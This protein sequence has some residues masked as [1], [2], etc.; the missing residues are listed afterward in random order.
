MAKLRIRWF[1][2]A[3]FLISSSSGVR[4]LTD[5]FDETVGYNLPHTAADIVTSSHDHFDHSNVSVAEGNPQILKGPGEYR[6]DK[7]SVYS[8]ETWHDTEH[9]ARRGKNHVFII[10]ADGVRIVH[11]GDIGHDLIPSQ[12]DA[13]GRVDVLLVPCGGYYTIDAE[14]AKRLVSSTNPRVVIPMHYRT[15]AIHDWPIARVDEFLKR[16]DNVVELDCSELELIP[17]A[18]PKDTTVYALKL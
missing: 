10:E 2:H 11:M 6:D 12:L 17:G 7:V 13:I 14:G 16:F 15:D 4:V 3:C 5:P 9:G 18:L 1:G 8:V